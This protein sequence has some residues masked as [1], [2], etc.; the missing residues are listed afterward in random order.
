MTVI[1]LLSLIRRNTPI[2]VVVFGS[3]DNRFERYTIKYAFKGNTQS[4][5]NDIKQK[6][7]ERCDVINIKMVFTDIY[8][9]NVQV[10][11]IACE[12]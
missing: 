11:Q 3:E 9:I 6:Q 7:L 1:E 2:R 4:V 12:E 10:L 5:I 8:G